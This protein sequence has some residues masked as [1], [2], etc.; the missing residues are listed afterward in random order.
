M[1]YI[2]LVIAGIIIGLI[3]A[4]PIGPVNLICIRRTLA[5]GSLNGFVSGMGAAI[6]DGVFAVVAAFG[7]TAVAQTIE[8][9]SPALQ[10]A[11]GTLLLF[12]GMHTYLTQPSPHGKR[13]TGTVQ[14]SAA[15]TLART[16][17]STFILT[18][19]NPAT[20]FGFAAMFAGLGGL[21]GDSMN[22][23]QACIVVGGVFAGSALWWFTLTTVVGTFHAKIDEAV[24][25]VINHLSGIAISAF[26]I[27]VLIHAGLRFF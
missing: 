15:S 17:V 19:T 3:A 25:R 27:A 14:E 23:V 6:G 11:G 13:Q 5:F 18:M 20:M 8:G 1:D 2:V 22:Y 26:G 4:A 24:M 7:L 21:T 9:V 10:F 12:F 16:I